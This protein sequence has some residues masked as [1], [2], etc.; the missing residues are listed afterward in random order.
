[1]RA[2]SK[3]A[4]AL[5]GF[6]VCGMALFASFAAP[7]A[8]MRCSRRCCTF[9]L[10]PQLAASFGRAPWWTRRWRGGCVSLN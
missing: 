7:L 5:D 6:I 4:F 1:M 8:D 10:H 3:C 9:A 2:V